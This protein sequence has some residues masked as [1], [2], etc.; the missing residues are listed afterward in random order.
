M[1]TTKKPT[2]AEL[3][4]A[5]KVK[6]S[7]DLNLRAYKSDLNEAYS[8]QMVSSLDVTMTRST[9]KVVVKPVL[10][11]MVMTKLNEVATKIALYIKNHYPET[12]KSTTTVTQIIADIK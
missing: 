5:E 1:T 9:G 10:N 4:A 11:K 2:T 6:M 8:D 12:Y 3:L 7:A